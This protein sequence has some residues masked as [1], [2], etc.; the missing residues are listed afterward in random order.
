[1]ANLCAVCREVVDSDLEACVYCRRM[2][3][4]PHR[5]RTLFH[6]MRVSWCSRCLADY[7]TGQDVPLPRK[8]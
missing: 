1:M 8:E 6:G 3:C 7:E 5:I 2:L 4:G